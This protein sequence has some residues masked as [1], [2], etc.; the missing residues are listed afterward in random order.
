MSTIFA[1]LILANRAQ[2]NQFT[3]TPLHLNRTAMIVSC[4]S[5]ADNNRDFDKVY[6]EAEESA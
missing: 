5:E 3:Q 6:F 4:H 1:L 2:Q